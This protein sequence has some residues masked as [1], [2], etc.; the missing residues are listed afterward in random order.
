LRV[1]LATVKG[2]AFAANKP[3]VGISSLDILAMNIE[4]ENAK[5]CALCDAKRKLVYACVYEKKDSVLIKKSGYFLESID[6]A[7]KRVK[8]KIV[9]IGD[10]VQLFRDNINKNKNINPTF[11]DKRLNLPQA[12]RLIPLALERFQ[13]G[14]IDNVADLVP[15]YLYPEYCQVRNGT[16]K[17][18]A[19]K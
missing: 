9:F 14:K 4:Q 15:L 18:H 16:Q 1:G 3:V 8:G 17:V 11:V 13:K 7:L 5:I 2:L 19:K 12:R 10:G 6:E